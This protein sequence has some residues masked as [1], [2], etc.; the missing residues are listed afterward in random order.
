MTETNQ[1]LNE[2]ADIKKYSLLSAKSMLTMD[3]ASLLTGLSKSRLYALTSAKQIPF[4][5]PRNKGI[6]FD[7][8]ELNNWL[9]HGRVQ[10]ADELASEAAKY[11]LQRTATND[12]ARKRT[13]R[14][15]SH[16]TGTKKGGK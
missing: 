6:Y 10:T 11:D 12:T 8:E 13:K 2:L 4:Y 14:T 5:K 3:E 15:T 16:T 1:I 7:K 9:R